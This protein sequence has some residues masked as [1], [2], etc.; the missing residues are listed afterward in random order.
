[1]DEFMKPGD[2]EH[3]FPTPE[4]RGQS[5]QTSTKSRYVPMLLK[6]VVAMKD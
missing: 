6:E 2:L 5:Q 4:V 1:M 3:E